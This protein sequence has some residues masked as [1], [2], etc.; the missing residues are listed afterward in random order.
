MTGIFIASS[1]LTMAI[2]LATFFA[3]QSPE[4]QKRVKELDRKLMD[5]GKRSVSW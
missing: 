4:V 3:A 5:L 1:I 2:I